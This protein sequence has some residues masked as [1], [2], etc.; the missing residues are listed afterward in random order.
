MQQLVIDG[1]EVRET[2]GGGMTSKHIGFFTNKKDA[3]AIASLNKSWRSYE[4]IKKIYTVFESV[5][6]FDNNTKEKLR[7]SAMAKL[8]DPEKEALGLFKAFK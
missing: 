5:D 8:T 4:P 1:Y 2:D 7:A 6:E 3:E